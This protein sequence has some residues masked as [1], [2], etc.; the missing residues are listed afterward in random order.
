L[1]G[2]RV[3]HTQK[4]WDQIQRDAQDALSNTQQRSAQ[5]NMPGS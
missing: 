5:S 2:P 1:P 4:E 3:C